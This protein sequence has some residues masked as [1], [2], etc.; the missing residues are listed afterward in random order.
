MKT[1]EFEYVSSIFNILKVEKFNN[2]DDFF[3]F[4]LQNNVVSFNVLPQ[5]EYF[6]KNI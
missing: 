5:E 3:A 4:L 2:L 1:K 6:L